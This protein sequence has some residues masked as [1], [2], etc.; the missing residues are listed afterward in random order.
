MFV[1]LF[2]SIFGFLAVSHP[3]QDPFIQRVKQ[4]LDTLATLQKIYISL[5]KLTKKFS[6]MI[7]ITI[8]EYQN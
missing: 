1:V 8:D 4:T 5:L 7:I 2:T 3:D 6:G